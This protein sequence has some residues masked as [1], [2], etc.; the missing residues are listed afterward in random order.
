M[1]RITRREALVVTGLA[2][3]VCAAST[4]GV[5]GLLLLR[6]RAA[7]TATPFP[8][9]TPDLPPQPIIVPRLAWGAREPDRAAPNEFGY[10]ESPL[11]NGW[12]VYPGDLAEVYN[13]VVI[14]HTAHAQ[15]TV[16]TMQDI[17]NLH[18]NRNGWADIGYHF[19]IDIEGNI[20]EGRD[21]GVRGSSVSGYNTGL[22]G[23]TLMGNFEVDQPTAAQLSATQK[24]VNWLAALY[25]LSHLAG[26]SE[27]N[28]NTVCPGESLASQLDT[29]ASIAGLQRGTGGYVAPAPG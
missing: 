9:S 3:T 27:F 8:S 14:H 16:E 24:L 17:Q 13:T 19:G 2:A 12:W 11:D 4:L 18:M 29:F 15:D 1:P 5:G 6:R 26:H 21:I 25:S 20:Y 28:S 23:V 22:I 7:P 10:A